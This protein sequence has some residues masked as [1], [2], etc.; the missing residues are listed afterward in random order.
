M[1]ALSD[2]RYERVVFMKSAQTGGTEIANN[3]VGYYMHQDPA[4]MLLV[5]PTLDMAKAWSKD[6]LAPMLRDTPALGG[7]VKEKRAKDSENTVLHKTFPGGHI[8]MA[9]ANSPASLASRPIR[10]TIFDEVDRFPPSAGPEGDPVSLGRKRSTTFWNRK[11]L[12]ISTP[13]VK[14][15]SRIEQSFGESTQDQYHVPCPHCQEMQ[16]LKWANCKWPD[17]EPEKAFYACEHCGGVIND[18]DL[19]AM[20]NAGEWVSAQPEK[21]VRGFHINEL[22]SPWVTFGQMASA[23]MQAKQFPDTLKTWV[24][25]ALGETWEEEGEALA[26]GLL[27]DRVEV[28][29]SEVPEGVV[30][31]TCGVDVQGDRLEAEVLGWG[32]GFEQWGVRYTVLYGDPSGPQLW[33]QLDQY[34]ATQFRHASGAEL[35]IA[36]TCIDSGGHHTQQVYA[37][38]KPRYRRRV[39][40]VKGVGGGGKPLVGRPSKSNQGKLPLYPVGVDTAKELIAARLQINEPGPGYA[41]FPDSYPPDYFDQLTAEKCVTRYTRGVPSRVWVKKSAGRRNE[42]LDVRVYNHAAFEILNPNIAVLRKR[43]VVDEQPEP[44]EE[45]PAPTTRKPRPRGRRG[46]GFVNGWR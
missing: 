36:A 39:Y 12:E 33:A 42:A 25:T 6:R 24:N 23:F 37:F 5:Q 2:P 30:V 14:G 38:C 26:D 9:G 8:T 34:L 35:R 7:L 29:D 41:H 40:A 28:Y 18:A 43:L 21:A 31:L 46:G 44:V 13:T 1:D 3:A 10:I 11:S 45:Q 17:N 15:A 27:S 20:L 32:D 19:P 16:T 22:Y 4:P